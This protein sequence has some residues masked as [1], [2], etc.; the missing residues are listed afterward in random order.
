M[1]LYIGNMP[2]GTN[3][4]ELREILVE[5]EPIANIHMP[6]DRETGETRGFAFVEMASRDLGEAAI[7]ALDGCDFNG[8]PLRISEAEDRPPRN[9]GGGGGYGGGGYGGGGYGGGGGGGRRGGGGGYDNNRRGGGGGKG[10]RKGGGDR[11]RHR[12]I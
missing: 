4:A 10:S 11:E 1:K 7:A 12:S 5:F 3:E 9:S 6:L 2:Y 8:R